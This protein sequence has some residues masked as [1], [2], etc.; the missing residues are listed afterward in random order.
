MRCAIAKI[1]IAHIGDL[2]TR[3]CAQ[4]VGT[5]TTCRHSSQSRTVT[6]A[7][8]ACV[9]VWL[10]ETGVDGND[11]GSARKDYGILS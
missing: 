2:G 3:L 6:H 9:I 4:C 5:V 8:T 10:R 1:S 11:Y 7:V